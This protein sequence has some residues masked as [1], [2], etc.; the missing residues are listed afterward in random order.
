MGEF[1]LKD[2]IVKMG[3]SASL[4]SLSSYVRS[5]TVT[6]MAEILDKTAMGSSAR[7]RI[8]GLK[9]FN[10]AVEFNQDFAGSKVDDTLWDYVGSTAQFIKLRSKSSAS[11]GIN[12]TFTGNVLLPSYS[13]IAGGVGDL[14][15]LSVTFQGDG[16]LSRR[17]SAT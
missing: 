8:A 17:T 3:S 4:V 16:I 6:Y 14:A 7:R 5:V 2:A 11:T 12:P 13:P 9:D 1:V 15:T 10:V